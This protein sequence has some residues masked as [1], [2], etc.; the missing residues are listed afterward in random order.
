M[1]PWEEYQQKPSAKQPWEEFSGE[2]GQKGFAA[3]LK[4]DYARRIGQM[5]GIADQAAAGDISK[6]EASARMGLKYAQLAP[7]VASEALVS[8]FRALP[9]AI[10]QPIREGAKNVYTAVADS[11]VGAAIGSAV[12]SYKDFEKEHPVAA[13]RIASVV[14][15][16]NLLAAFAP[17]KGKSAISTAGDAATGTAGVVGKGAAKVA[18]KATQVLLP[19]VDD[20][21][22]EVGKLAQKYDIPLSFDQ[23]SKSRA[24]K[25]VQKISQEV[26]L[27]GQQAFRDEQLKAFNRALFKTV[28]VEADSFTPET[29]NIAFKK[30][31]GEFDAL[32][33]G[34][35]F[36]IGGTFIDDITS[37]ADEV[38]STY[39][40]DAA[41]IYQKE[42]L[43]VI[44]DFSKGDVISGEL[45]SRQRGRINAL[46]RKATDPNIKGAL[47]DLENNIVDAITS[48]DKGIE[49]MLATAKQRYKNLIVLEP[50]ANSA[51]GG[52]ISP[53]KLNNR[54]SQVYKRAHTIGESGDIGNLA[55]IGHE[56]LP[57][58]GGSDTTQKMAYLAAVA[59]GGINP[60]SIP[61][62]A[63][64]VAANRAFQ[65]GIN[66]NQ[67]LIDRAIVKQAAKLPPAE[68]R[69]LLQ[70][71]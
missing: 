25:N 46:A 24:L 20:G 63:T 47:L 71:K 7:D 5:E 68:A 19:K 13:G 57:E 55:R 37:T 32:T 31:G 34:R 12:N 29:M 69:K 62:I 70:K 36:N 43:R 50:I 21:L 58:L 18:G 60:A 65:S 10:E 15:A 23:I 54:V 41:A 67:S 9:D 33:K 1:Q 61:A 44:D 30:V 11:P 16:G 14:D 27:S 66:R 28:G 40:K 45:I 52:V 35:D 42:A 59:T 6:L 49:K 51:K 56:L 3:R 4:D 22:I 2:T 53:S 17:I 26:P 38:A 48:K 39:G 8:G 64:G